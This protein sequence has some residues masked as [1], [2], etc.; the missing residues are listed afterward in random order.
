[1][2]NQRPAMEVLTRDQLR[3]YAR[4]IALREV[5]GTGQLRLLRA[6]VRLVGAGPGAEEAAR[7]LA[8]AGV[9]QL[10]LDD[11][12]ASRLGAE[13]AALNPDC[14]VAS[15]SPSASQGATSA[16]AP[17]PAAAT[18]PDDAAPTLQAGPVEPD[19]RLAGSLCAITV[20]ARVV[21]VGAGAAEGFVWETARP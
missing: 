8:A 10:T 15:A 4:H 9:G 12:L 16:P 11:T 21:G 14:R 3:R 2:P 6:H 13:L 5:G 20:V 17:A 7:Y 1:M 18:G 19:D